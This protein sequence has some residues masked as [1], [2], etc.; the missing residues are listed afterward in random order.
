MRTAVVPH[1]TV[2]VLSRHKRVLVASEVATR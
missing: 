1:A 2:I